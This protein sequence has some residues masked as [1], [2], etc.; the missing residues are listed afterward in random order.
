MGVFVRTTGGIGVAALAVLAV[1][2]SPASPAEAVGRRVITIPCSSTALSTAI[3][4]A[5]GLGA[6]TLRLAA[7]CSYTITTPATATDGLPVV[8]G[9]VALVGGP[10]TTIRR[11]PAIAAL[12]RVLEVSAG[13]T[14]RVRN[15]A[16]LNGNN[17]GLGGG[18]LD[19][20]T[21]ELDH[22]TLSGNRAN[23][24]GAISITAGAR[25]FVTRSVFSAN[26]TTGVG[27]GGLIVFGTVTVDASRFT[28]NS[29]P[30]NGGAVDTQP[31][32]TARLTHDTID[33]NSSNGL[34]G[35]IANLGTTVLQ[36]TLVE[37]NRGSGGGG[38]ATA[39]ASIFLRRSIVRRNLPNNCN[40]LNTIPGCTD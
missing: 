4:T 1:S 27:G 14:L 37:L 25:G 23:N 29:A 9:D 17:G 26:S 10:A 28:G 20:G 2:S 38:I 30:I 3:T 19:G 22:V 11:D 16:I 31:G 33:H 5:N 12:F 32:G 36:N 15:I 21:L 13:G 6:A 34:G 18:I 35:G 40:P 39:N 7:H 24:G 8:T